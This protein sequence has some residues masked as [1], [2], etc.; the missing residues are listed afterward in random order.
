MASL[1][2]SFVLKELCAYRRVHPS[3]VIEQFD[4]SDVPTASQS[5]AW[6]AVRLFSEQES[7]QHR[8]VTTSLGWAI[9]MCSGLPATL[10]CKKHS[11]SRLAESRRRVDGFPA[12]AFVNWANRCSMAY[13]SMH[14]RVVSLSFEPYVL[15][16]AHH[17]R[18]WNASSFSPWHFEHRTLPRV[19]DTRIS[20][21]LGGLLVS[22]RP[23]ATARPLGLVE[24]WS[25]SV[26]VSFVGPAVCG[27][28]GACGGGR[29]EV[30]AI[31]PDGRK[32]CYRV[33]IWAL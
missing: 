18:K 25:V 2:T 12:T 26:G 32:R 16:A 3:S 8:K 10:D 19:S 21:V 22:R 29:R 7:S 33:L 20:S 24:K 4:S 23:G 15:A 13:S 11:N 6:T 30:G 17:W 1:E 14:S 5:L 27:T 9:T 28:C 31:S